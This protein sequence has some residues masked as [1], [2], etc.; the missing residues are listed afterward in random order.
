MEKENIQAQSVESYTSFP[1]ILGGRV[2]TLHPKIHGG[3]LGRRNFPEDQ[4][5][6][7]EHGIGRIDLLI[8]NLY[9]FGQTIADENVSLETAV[10]NIDIGGPAMLRSAA[11][12][13]GH[14][15][16][17]CDPADYDTVITEWREQGGIRCKLC[18]EMSCKAF[19]H[20]ANYDSMV[21]NYFNGITKQRLPEN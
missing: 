17:L 11:K 18:L 9:P 7:Q 12:N 21:A 15:L 1:E 16:V 20:T 14:T 19:N 2:K 8:V 6:L 3:L 13:F 10:E 4:S 5:A